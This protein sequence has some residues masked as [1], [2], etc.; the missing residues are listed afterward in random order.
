MVILQAASLL[1]GYEPGGLWRAQAAFGRGDRLAVLWQGPD[2]YL[3]KSRTRDRTCA[4]DRDQ[5]YPDRL[6]RPFG[7]EHGG[8]IC[9]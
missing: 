1:C 6:D 7:R 3:A 8:I 2:K 5:V 4:S 9:P